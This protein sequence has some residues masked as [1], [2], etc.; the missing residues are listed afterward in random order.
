MLIIK[1]LA[2]QIREELHDAEKY[3]KGSLD[4][5]T[6]CPQLAALYNRLAGEEINHAMLLH[7]EAVRQIEKA[8]AEKPVPPVMREIWAWQHDELIEQERDVRRLMEMYKR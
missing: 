4:K 7:D 1:E 6:D 2:K 8:A 3:A 5:K